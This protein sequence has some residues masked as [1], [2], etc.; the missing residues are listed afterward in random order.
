MGSQ[1]QEFQQQTRHHSM[2]ALLQQST[3]QAGF[4]QQA[5]QNISGQQQSVIN[6]QLIVQQQ[7]EQMQLLNIQTQLTT[8][9]TLFSQQMNLNGSS[10]QQYIYFQ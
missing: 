6:N 1:T 7:Q 8:I 5:S 4:G 2:K 9:M 3:G 10:S